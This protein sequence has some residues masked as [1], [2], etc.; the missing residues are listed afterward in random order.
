MNRIGR[1]A[2]SVGLLLALL[3]AGSIPSAGADDKAREALDRATELKLQAKTIGDLDAVIKKAEEALTAGLPE[4]DQEFARELIAACHFEKAQ[5]IAAGLR[6]GR[7]SR[8]WRTLRRMA[9]EELDKVLSIQ[10]GLTDARLLK[11]EIL[12]MEPGDA[13]KA[14]EVIDSALKDIKDPSTRAA[15]LLIRARTHEKREDALTD[16]E[17]A[18]KAVP[19]DRGALRM[20]AELLLQLEQ[21]DKAID[22]LRKLHEDQPDDLVVV[23]A[24]VEALR[25]AKQ[26][27]EAIKVVGALIEQPE[28]RLV[29]LRM[30]AEIHFDRKAYDD[31]IRDA[32]EI[33]ESNPGHLET[34]LLRARANYLKE[35]YDAALKDLDRVLAQAPGEP[36]VLLLRSAVHAGKNNYIQAIRDLE[37]V[38]ERAPDNVDLKIQLGYYHL[39]DDRPR[40]AI[41]YFSEILK[42][43]PENENALRA[44]ADAYLAIGE[45]AKAVAD[46]NKALPHAQKNSGLLNNL[47]W[48]LATSPDDAVRDG[49]RALELAKKACELTDYKAPHIL[50]TLASAHAELGDFEEAR[51]WSKKAVE[52][53]KGRDDLE[54]LEKELASYEAEKPWREKQV[55]KEKP[56]PP[57][58]DPEGERGRSDE[59]SEGE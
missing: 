46:Y 50:S 11:A 33:L 51:K 3:W 7:A 49:K 32:N 21:P 8:R 52:L 48:V 55:T 9:L 19:N 58:S 17:A 57:E 34:V 24:L 45:H 38:L 2:C 6:A 36:Q 53:G 25:Q 37:K 30:R 43:D 5:R 44:R 1:F 26:Y 35:D 31:V 42:Q 10:K 29:G 22:D 47:A 14:K 12:V 27:D 56:W 23:A 54:Q 4:A 16:V 20:R 41:E 59:R 18:L 13:A 15:A 39:A 40:K 28:S